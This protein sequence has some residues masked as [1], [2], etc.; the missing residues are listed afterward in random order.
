[1]NTHEL[2]RSILAKQPNGGGK[3]KP[4]SAIIGGVEIMQRSRESVQAFV[5]R[6]IEMHRRV[7]EQGR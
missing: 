3:T 1:M 4:L 5:A 7:R 6:S 2:L